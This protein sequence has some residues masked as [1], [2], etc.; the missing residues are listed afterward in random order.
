MGGMGAI[1]PG[2]VP[3][4]GVVASWEWRARGQGGLKLR[5]QVGCGADAANRMAYYISV[6]E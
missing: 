4:V 6:V 1:V 3:S 2:G 5:S